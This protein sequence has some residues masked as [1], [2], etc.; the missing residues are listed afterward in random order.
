MENIEFNKL[1]FNLYELLNLPVKSSTDEIK[2]KFKKLIKMFHPDKIT[3]VEE[4]IYYN[5]TIANHILGNEELRKKYDSWLLESH[6]SH[7][8][9]KDNFKS[10]EQMIREYF[11]QSKEE[12]QVEFSKNFEMLGNRHGNIV[13]D[14]RPLQTVYKDK[15]KERK[16][17]SISKEDFSNMDEFNNRFSE[18]KQKGVYSTQIVK[19]NTDIQ[20][21]SFKGTSS[22]YAQLKD[23]D[24]VYINDDQYRYAFE[25]MPSDESKMTNKT[26]T[27]R[28]DDYNNESNDLKKNKSSQ[29]IKMNINNFN[30]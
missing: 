28:M 5:L 20:P 23:F 4:T 16:N 12:A 7:S 22:N 30:F 9:L 11:P 24:K 27:Q 6:K 21:F 26:I 10:D 14:T 13:N 1:E 29:N 15:E 8:T 25:L 18:R 2:K 3:E 17:V 19:R